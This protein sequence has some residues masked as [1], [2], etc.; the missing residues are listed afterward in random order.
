MTPALLTL[1]GLLLRGSQAGGTPM[2]H[3]KSP[4]DPRDAAKNERAAKDKRAA[5]VLWWILMAMRFVIPAYILYV[6]YLYWT[7]PLSPYL[8]GPR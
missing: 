3:E 5:R 7:T 4:H 6:V 1:T 2:E 8:Q